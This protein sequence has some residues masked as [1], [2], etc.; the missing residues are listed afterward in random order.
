MAFVDIGVNIGVHSLYMAMMGIDTF[1]VDPSQD[2]LMRVNIH[3]GLLMIIIQR[4]S[5]M[6]L[7]LPCSQEELRS[8]QGQPLQERGRHGQAEGVP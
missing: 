6:Y 4:E 7:G 2:N 5:D 1:G 3:L 8:E